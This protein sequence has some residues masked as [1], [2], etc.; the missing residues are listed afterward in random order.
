M[1]IVIE[2]IDGVGKSTQAELLKRLIL[3]HGLQADIL[4]F[5]RYEQTLFGKSIIDYL[6][7]KFGTLYEVIPQFAALLYAGDRFESL[8]LLNKLIHCNDVLILDRYIASNL[9][10]QAAKVSN[11]QT[12]QLLAWI[13]EIEY[14]VYNLPKAD[15]TIHLDIP[16][17]LAQKMIQQKK[18]RDYTTEKADIHEQDTLYLEKCRQ[19]YQLLANQNYK[20]RWLTL[21][22]TNSKGSLQTVI[23]IQE[24]IFQALVNE[25][26]FFQILMKMS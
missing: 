1:L 7:G 5:P 15:I 18:Q 14:N 3:Q 21:D 22:C 25:P 6:N 10:H 9:A 26:L 20:S 8:N 13:A 16:A 4:K 12:E 11:A 2:G 19:I 24:A 23:E 17:K